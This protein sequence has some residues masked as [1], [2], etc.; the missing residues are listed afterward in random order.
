MSETEGRP[1][2]L[3][4]LKQFY[5]A[6]EDSKAKTEATNK[7]V[8]QCYDWLSEV[9]SEE[10]KSELE[11]LHEANHEECHKKV[12]EYLNRLGEDKRG[13][14][15]EKLPFCEHV[16]YGQAHKHENP[17]NDSGKEE[18]KTEAKEENKVDEK[19]EEH[20]HEHHHA[21][22]RWVIF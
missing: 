19:K 18:E 15:E 14:I 16:W 11:Q 13:Q 17:E 4:K 7:I 21:K 22:K 5:D 10:E 1:A 3:V 6:L 2:R 9:V 12:H 20:Q 8:E